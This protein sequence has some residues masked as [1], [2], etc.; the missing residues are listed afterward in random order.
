[1]NESSVRFWQAVTVGII[2][3]AAILLIAQCAHADAG[4][5]AIIA[6]KVSALAAAGDGCAVTVRYF[7]LRHVHLSLGWP[8]ETYPAV[9]S[10]VRVLVYASGARAM[11]W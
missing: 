3:M 8:C 4:P 9:G 7:P 2:V 6:G 10:R 5:R 11:E 1:M